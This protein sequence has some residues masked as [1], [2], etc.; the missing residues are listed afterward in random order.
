M[1]RPQVSDK[2]KNLLGRPRVPV[3]KRDSGALK[4]RLA[5][6]GKK[7]VIYELSAV[8]TILLAYDAAEGLVSEFI[9]GHLAR[10]PGLVY[11]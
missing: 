5:A 7:Q 2:F 10:D 6:I 4:N 8:E 9:G 11:C 1:N 3:Y